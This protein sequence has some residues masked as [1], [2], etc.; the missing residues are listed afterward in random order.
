MRKNLKKID[1]PLLIAMTLLAAFGLLM[2]FSSSS[3]SAILRYNESTYFFFLKQLI[4]VI[5]SYF[6]GLFIL[7]IP[8]QKYSKYKLPLALLGIVILAGLFIIGQTRNNANSWYDLGFFTLQP[9]EFAKTI[10]IIVAACYY[11]LFSKKNIPSM[12]PYGIPLVYGFILVALVIAQPDFGSALIILALNCALFIAVPYV[13][14]NIFKYYKVIIGALVLFIIGMILFGSDIINSSQMQRFIYSDP[15]SRYTE[16]TGY[17]V[18]NSLIAISNGGMF[19]VGLGNSTQ[20]YLYLPESHTDF[21]FP[22]IVEELGFVT[23]VLV[24]L[25][26]AFILYR[27]LV[28]A[29]RAHNLRNSLIAYGAFVVIA[30]HIMI[31]ILGILAVIPLTGVPLPLLS[32]GGSSTLNFLILLFLSQRVSIESKTNEIKKHLKSL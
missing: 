19:G 16:A 9:A 22:I 7:F 25:L 8:T 6:I 4:F 17:Q 10:L 30:V 27:L 28:I 29:K 11:N 14:K 20:K 15:C 18:C 32:Y 24:L 31:N 26:Y 12:L 21:I 1:M 5:G 23:G 13:S 2:V 3:V